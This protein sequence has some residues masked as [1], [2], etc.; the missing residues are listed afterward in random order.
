MSLKF[1]ILSTLFAVSLAELAADFPYGPSGW[2]PEGAS[3]D[4]PNEDFFTQ[5]QIAPRIELEITKERVDHAGQLIQNAPQISTNNAYLPSDEADQVL[6]KD[7]IRVQGLPRRPSVQFNGSPHLNIREYYRQRQGSRFRQPQQFLSPI[8]FPSVQNKIVE[9][10][11]A[12]YKISKNQL[13]GVYTNQA[14]QEEL[15]KEEDIAEG[16]VNKGEYFVLTPERTLQKVSYKT[17]QTEEEA[18][19]NAF[20]AELKYTP[21][22]KVEGPL[23]KYNEQGQLVRIYKK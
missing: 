1:A 7:I 21:V 9:Q 13:V 4:L 20:T 18:R 10:P 11:S 23:Y 5:P 19:T 15:N 2:K 3:F 17:S 12:Q 6:I 8:K 14:P 16:F 22:E